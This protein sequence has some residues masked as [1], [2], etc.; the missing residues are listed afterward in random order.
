MNNVERNLINKQICY[1]YYFVKTDSAIK[2]VILNHFF[3]LKITLVKNKENNKIVML[4]NFAKWTV[5][6]SII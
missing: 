3:P 1:C 2:N 6:Q 5:I 4:T